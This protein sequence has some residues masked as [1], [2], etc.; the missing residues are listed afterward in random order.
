MKRELLFLQL[1]ECIDPADA[2]LLIRVKD[3]GLK[4]IQLAAVKAAWPG[5]TKGW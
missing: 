3:K 5:L 1:L 4:G 2:K